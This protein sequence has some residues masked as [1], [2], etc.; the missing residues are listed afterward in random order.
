MK[1][2]IIVGYQGSGKTTLSN[3]LSR[4]FNYNV[5]EF[6]DY[7]RNIYLSENRSMSL[8][9]Y[10]DSIFKQGENLFFVKK[11]NEQITE[12]ENNIFVGP[13]TIAEIDYLCDIYEIGL[14]IG[15]KCDK[16]I[17][18]KRRKQQKKFCGLNEFEKR[19]NL[20][21]SWGVAKIFDCCDLIFNTTV[22]NKK[23]ICLMLEEEISNI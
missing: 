7:V 11:I 20:E 10:V 17:R 3:Q 15:L 8:L 21:Q 12:N 23:D 16:S 14:I 19:E 5:I 6:G 13:R 1:N 2:I 4:K 9:N 22:L 18:L